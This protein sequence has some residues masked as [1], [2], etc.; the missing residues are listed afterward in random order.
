MLYIFIA[1]LLSCKYCKN[2]EAT[3]KILADMT[4]RDMERLST[5]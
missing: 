2:M 4:K 1:F 3:I 5:D